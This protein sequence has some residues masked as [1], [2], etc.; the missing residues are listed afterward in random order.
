VTNSLTRGMFWKYSRQSLM[1]W[2]INFSAICNNNPIIR[3]QDSRHNKHLNSCSVTC[4]WWNYIWLNEGFATFFEFTLVENTNPDM[5]IRDYF[6]IQKLQNTLKMDAFDA[7]SRPMTHYADTPAEISNLFDRVAYDKC[8]WNVLS[9]CTSCL[10]TNLF[11]SG[12]CHKN[13]PA[14]CRRHAF[15]SSIE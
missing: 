12:K 15:P 4:S 8:E 1:S 14:L 13:V 11:H 2:A 6:N 5:R 3:S 10:I 9:L 7:T